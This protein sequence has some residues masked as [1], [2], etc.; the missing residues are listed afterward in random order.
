MIRVVETSYGD[1]QSPRTGY[2]D[3]NARLVTIETNEDFL[4]EV[5]SGALGGYIGVWSMAG[6]EVYR[7]VGDPVVVTVKVVNHEEE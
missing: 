4:I 5:A 3:H 1:W 7:E 2:V 6:E